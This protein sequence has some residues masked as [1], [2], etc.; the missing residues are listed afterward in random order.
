VEALLLKRFATRKTCRPAMPES[1][2]RGREACCLSRRE[3][4][5]QAS[6]ST[7]GEIACSMRSASRARGPGHPITSVKQHFRQ[8]VPQ[9]QVLRILRPFF[10]QVDSPAR[11]IFTCPR[12]MRFRAAV[13]ARRHVQF[14]RRVARC[15]HLVLFQHLPERLQ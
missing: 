3:P 8:L 7:S 1:R 15:R 5:Q 14:F 11:S 12:G 4:L 9:H 2:N 13:T 10:C 6:A